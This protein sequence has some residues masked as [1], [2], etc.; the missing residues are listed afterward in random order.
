MLTDKLRRMNLELD[1]TKAPWEHN[2]A[3]QWKGD[4][5]CVCLP[6]TGD[7]SPKEIHIFSTNHGGSE[8]TMEKNAKAT[9][10]S[11][12]PKHRKVRFPQ[13]VLSDRAV[14]RCASA[15]MSLRWSDS[16]HRNFLWL[17]GVFFFATPLKKW[18]SESQL[19]LLYHIIPHMMGKIHLVGSFNPSE[20]Y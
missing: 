4:Q 19:G 20:K 7:V 8:R 3:D 14:L 11:C 10:L 18:W 13:F 15:A 16:A 12:R 17:V 9:I 2:F 6:K 5:P 1:D